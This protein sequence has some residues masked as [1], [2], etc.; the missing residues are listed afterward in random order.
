MRVLEEKR[1]WNE[2]NRERGVSFPSA[3]KQE[4]LLIIRLD[5]KPNVRGEPRLVRQGLK[6]LCGLFERIDAG[7]VKMIGRR[8]VGDVRS[9]KAD[10]LYF[11]RDSRIRYWFF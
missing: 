5:L 6:R 3:F 2:K 4:Y 7:E 10:R 1:L 11:L 8:M 9:S